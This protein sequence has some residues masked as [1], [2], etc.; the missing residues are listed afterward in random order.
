MEQAGPN[1]M[2][3]DGLNDEFK[4][5]VFAQD[6][7]SHLNQLVELA[8]RLD[9][10]F[11]LHRHAHENS[12]DQCRYPSTAHSLSEASTENRDHASGKGPNYF[13]R[14]STLHPGGAL[15]VLRWCWSFCYYLSSKSKSSAVV[16]E[17]LASRTSISPPLKTRTTFEAFVHCQ[18]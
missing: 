6:I 17:V 3:S 15:P 10:R 1:C 13:R 9:K 16:R 8:T 5:E 2:L 7:P 14:A 12:L 18:G 11:D 4:D